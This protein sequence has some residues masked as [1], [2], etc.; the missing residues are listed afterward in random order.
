MT[1][2]LI[3][4]VRRPKSS[5]LHYIFRGRTRTLSNYIKKTIS[6]ERII[7]Y[8]LSLKTCAFLQDINFY[9]MVSGGVQVLSSSHFYPL[10]SALY[11]GMGV[12]A[13]L[14]AESESYRFVGELWVSQSLS[15]V[16]SV[17]L[18]TYNE[19]LQ[20]IQEEAGKISV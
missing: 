10:L 20:N 16:C 13:V 12:Q 18:N 5:F 4:S 15:T 8:I 17:Q 1:I 11:Q 19:I 6:N 7:L 14:R 2:N 9:E 3:I